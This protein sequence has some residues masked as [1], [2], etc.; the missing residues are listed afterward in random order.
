MNR[1]QEKELEIQRML[2]DGRLNR[3]QFLGR[4]SAMGIAAT[5]AG[6]LWSSR[7]LANM[8]KMGGHMRCGLNDANTIDSL[9]STAYNATT[10]IVISRSIRDSIVDVGIDGQATPNLAESWE[11][12]PDAKT[13]RFKIRQGVE[14][15]D[16]MSGSND[17]IKA[18]TVEDVINSINVHRGEDTKSAAKGVFEGV[19]DVRADGNDTVV[20]EFANANADGPFI[21]T[22]YH[23]SV[24]PTVDGKAD[25]FSSAGT[26]CYFL[27]EFDPG[28]RTTLEKNPNSWQASELGF[29][30]SVEIIAILDDNARV[31]ALTSGSVDVI[32]RP[33]LKTIHLLKM[34]P[35]VSIVDVPSNLAYTH[36][37]RTDVPPFD[38]NDFRLALKYSTPRQDFVDKILFGYGFVGNDQPLGPQ[39]PSFD[40]NLQ[41]E[42]DLD[43]ARDHLKKSGLEG[44]EFDMSTSDTA[45][46]GAVD[47]AQLFAENWQAIGLRPNIIREPKDGYWSDVWNKKPF[48]ACYWGPRPIEDLILSIAYV[49]G[50]PWND[51]VI[52]IPRVD[53]LVVMARGELDQAKRT[54]MYQEVQQL[55]SMQGGTIIPA[56]GSDIAATNDMVG[57]PEK[58][59]GGWEMDG[60]HFVKRWWMKG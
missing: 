38:N 55:I 23:F 59:G 19:S 14:F 33:D 35:G 2:K 48:C 26:G 15:Y 58:I 18:L 22:D 12:S 44:A 57:V 56:F 27:R 50:A 40:R 47:A 37:M 43:K 51:T 25:L 10:M 3:R 31:T 45:Y 29:A 32:N 53:E 34:A 52:S 36:P 21:F 39:F 16:G 60:G 7:A 46:G 28:V 1:K 9:D 20:V 30:D 54:E 42:F 41:V 24:V 13:W 4:T 5:T 8:P 6:G 49:T 17:P 11:S